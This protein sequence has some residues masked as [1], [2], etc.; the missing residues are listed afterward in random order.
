MRKP[1]TS[2]YK[3]AS[4]PAINA[5]ELSNKKE[6]ETSLLFQASGEADWVIY[7]L[8]ASRYGLAMEVPVT[9]LRLLEKWLRKTLNQ[10]V[11]R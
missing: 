8:T 7:Q 1:R 5:L 9:L 10:R 2:Q 3:E 4:P 6:R 11:L